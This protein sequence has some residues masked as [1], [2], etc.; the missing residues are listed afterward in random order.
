MKQRWMYISKS[1]KRPTKSR[2]G[3]QS[4]DA[5]QKSFVEPE[6]AVAEETATRR[7]LAAAAAG[8]KSQARRARE[9]FLISKDERDAAVWRRPQRFTVASTS[10]RA[11][12]QFSPALPRRNEDETRIIHTSESNYITRT[13]WHVFA[14]F[15][16]KHRN[17][18]PGIVL[19]WNRANLLYFNNLK[20]LKFRQ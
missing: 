7:Q 5:R 18:C 9:C 1:T 16:G 6:A 14:I 2:E 15:S 13:F 17:Y 3:R 4:S 10:F 12:E 11:L 8:W 19:L 20:I